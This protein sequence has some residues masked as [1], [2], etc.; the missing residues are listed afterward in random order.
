MVLE[1]FFGDTLLKP[2]G[3][4]VQTSSLSTSEGGVVGVYFSAHWCPPCRGFTPKLAAVYNEIKAQQKDFEIVFVSWD[5]DEDSFKAYHKEMPWLAIPFDNSEKKDSLKSKYQVRG[6]PTLVLVAADTGET[7]KAEG[8]DVIDE[9]GAEGF[10]FTEERL[11]AAKGEIKAKKE[12]ALKELSDLKFLG[13]LGTM[14]EPDKHL[15]LDEVTR[16]SE[17]LA[18]AF[19]KGTGCQGSTLVLPKLLDIQKQLGKEKLQVIVVPVMSDGGPNFPDAVLE[20]MKGVVMIPRGERAQQ[21]AK[22]FEGVLKEIDAPHVF[23]VDARDATS[24]KF[25]ADNAA[26]PIYFQ[27]EAAYPWSDEAIA[28]LEEREKKLKEEMKAKQKNLEFF[29]PSD[30]CHIVNK[31]GSAVSLSTLQGCDVVGIYFSAHWCGPCKSFTPKLVEVYNACKENNKSFEVI[32]MSS[33][34]NQEAFDEYYA[35]MP[36]CTLKYEDRSLKETLSDIFE[37]QG[38]PTLILLKGN[39]DVITTNGRSAVAAGAEGFP[40]NE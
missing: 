33:D 32:F 29:A 19:M 1:S 27:G 14:D 24:M 26:R 30:G 5:S 11:V 23:V 34:R 25:V 9:Y 22:K 6:I 3:T 37:V 40:W 31:A 2:D 36:W 38:I 21:V 8:R 10:P 12:E 35:E 17:A 4:E 15:D 7:V 28:A 18:F 20:K 39:G 13:D 16:G